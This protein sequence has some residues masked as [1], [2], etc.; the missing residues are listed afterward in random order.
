MRR[1]FDIGSED[2]LQSFSGISFLESFSSL[3]IPRAMHEGTKRNLL[4]L[5]NRNKPPRS[6]PDSQILCTGIIKSLIGIVGMLDVKSRKH[7]ML[8]LQHAFKEAIRK[9]AKKRVVTPEGIGPF[10][11]I[12]FLCSSHTNQ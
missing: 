9:V 7:K 10:C 5:S 11:C 8:V 12:L 6:R 4:F 1:T 3:R 2:N